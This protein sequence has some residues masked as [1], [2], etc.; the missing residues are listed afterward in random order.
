MRTK[1]SYIITLITEPGE[2]NEIAG[3][4]EIVKNGECQHFRSWE[5]LKQKILEGLK[6]RPIGILSS[7]T[8]KSEFNNNWME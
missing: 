4:L 2:E 3:K 5:E 6:N 7:R 1:T 8:E